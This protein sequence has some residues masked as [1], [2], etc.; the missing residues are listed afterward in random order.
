MSVAWEL[1]QQTPD[2]EGAG[3]S[4]SEAASQPDASKVSEALVTSGREPMRMCQWQYYS[5]TD[6][7]LMDKVRICLLRNC[8]KKLNPEDI[9][10]IL[11]SDGSA[12]ALLAWCLNM[13]AESR[14]QLCRLGS[15]R[16]L[17]YL[18]R[19]GLSQSPLMDF[20]WTGLP[21]DQVMAEMEK[22]TMTARV[23]VET[24]PEKTVDQVMA[25]ID[26]RHENQKLLEWEYA[27][28]RPAV[29]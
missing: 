25:E 21:P 14:V 22:S 9:P 17:P 10:T 29:K 19:C 3:T 6:G 7:G 18:H 4:Q 28:A 1:P 16:Y 26:I 13:G 23:I 12:L 24:S 5:L 20:S 11:S 8:L 15:S 2:T 27:A